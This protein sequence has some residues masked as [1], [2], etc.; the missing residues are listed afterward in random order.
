MF[1]IVDVNSIDSLDGLSNVI[2][3]LSPANLS[4]FSL[5]LTLTAWFFGIVNTYYWQEELYRM[6]NKT[7]LYISKGKIVKDIPNKKK[8]KG[9]EYRQAKQIPYNM[10][11]HGHHPN[12]R[13]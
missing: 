1:V 8:P 2:V 5:T 13:K 11:N 12:Y 9:K 10:P 4:G 3:I 7:D 6:K